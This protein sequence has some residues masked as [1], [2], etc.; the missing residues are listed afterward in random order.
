[1]VTGR[2]KTMTNSITRKE[3]EAIKNDT[4]ITVVSFENNRRTLSYGGLNIIR[5][6]D[7]VIRNQKLGR[8]SLIIRN[9]PCGETSWDR[10]DY[11]KYLQDNHFLFLNEYNN[12]IADYKED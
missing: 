9:L 10:K 2:N 11:E 1:M 8:E 7:E 6:I 3:Y 4:T 5:A 12:G